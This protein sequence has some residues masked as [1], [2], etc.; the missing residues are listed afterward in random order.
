MNDAPA[1]SAPPASLPLAELLN[2]AADAV[3]AVRAGTSLNEAL[4][5]CPA[6]ARPGT[7]ALAFLVL[8]RLGSAQAARARLAP[9]A[10]PPRVDALLLAALALLWPDDAAPYADH[11]LVDQAVAAMHRRAPKSAAF[12]NAVLRRFVRER[13]AIVAALQADPV[14]RDNHPAWWLERLQHDWPGDWQA[15][16]AADNLHAP[17]T[18]RVNAR[19][20]S[21]AA[22]VQRLA[23]H[24]IGA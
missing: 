12:A 2:R 4:A 11:T 19:R 8:R 7:Q 6:A 18:L 3:Q 24:G 21:A 14:A 23:Q 22:Y 15:I 17:M 9:K 5:R 13:A 20:S 16:V 10:P 1:A